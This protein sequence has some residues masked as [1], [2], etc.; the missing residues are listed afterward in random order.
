[1]EME[2]IMAHLLAELKAGLRTNRDKADVS[3][4][5]MKAEMI[6]NQEKTDANLK[7]IQA[8]QEHLKE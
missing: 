2:Q 7:E 4:R 1:M 5:E 3:L 8:G 6:T